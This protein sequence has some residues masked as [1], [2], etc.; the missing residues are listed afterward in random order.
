ML[1]HNLST[2]H[3]SAKTFNEMDLL[4]STASALLIS[5]NHCSTRAARVAR[6]SIERSAYA[7]HPMMSCAIESWIFMAVA[8]W[9]SII[10][11]NFEDGIIGIHS[12]G[13]RV[14]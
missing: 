4:L 14:R 7:C 6:I 1:S 2:S 3:T 13:R 8:L 10:L 12:S 11:T 9:L 5:C